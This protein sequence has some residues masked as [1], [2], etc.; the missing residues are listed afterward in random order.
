[1]NKRM[2]NGEKLVHRGV[3]YL[4]TRGNEWKLGWTQCLIEVMKVY[5]LLGKKYLP[6]TLRIFHTSKL[7]NHLAKWEK[8]FYA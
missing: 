6:D 1:M 7:T 8:L 2:E 5:Q 3:L 4:Q